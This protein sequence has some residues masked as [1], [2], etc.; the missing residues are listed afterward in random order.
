M[1]D[2]GPSVTRVR[3]ASD[4]EGGERAGCRHP[5]DADAL[6]DAGRRTLAKEREERLEV[7]AGAFRDAS[8]GSIGEIGHPANQAQTLRLA[9][10]EITEADPMDTP[11]DPGVE[12][13]R[14]G[15]DRHGPSGDRPAARPRQRERVEQEL[16]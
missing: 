15:F 5:R 8:N 2:R 4:A 9:K 14:I 16:G 6:H 3:A 12:A 13:S 1:A 10:D 7:A 11:G